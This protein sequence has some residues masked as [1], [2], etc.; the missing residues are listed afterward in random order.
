MTKMI[1]KPNY[2][3]AQDLAYD[4]LKTS[5][6][7]IFPVSPT[8]IIDRFTKIKIM[9]YTDFSNL[10]NLSIDE[11][12]NFLGSDDGATWNKPASN[13]TIIFYNDEIGSNNRIRF[14]LAHELGHCLLGHTQEKGNFQ[15]SCIGMNDENYDI[16]EKEAN[17]F[18]KRLLVPLPFFTVLLKNTT[19][20]ALS[21][22]DISFIF[23]VSP[24]VAQY[25][26]L[27]YNKLIIPPTDDSLCIP[28]IPQLNKKLSYIQMAH[29]FI[30]MA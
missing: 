21:K 20:D 30:A 29:K 19:L 18:A 15:S 8:K 9:K 7:N 24:Q 28:Y 27:N 6:N 2:Q 11:T 5:N 14:T 3:K 4:V 22:D 13:Q 26:I 1:N 17:Y 10:H 12:C 25:S 16:H 23:N